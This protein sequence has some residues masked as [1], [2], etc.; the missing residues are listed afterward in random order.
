[1]V[2]VIHVARTVPYPVGAFMQSPRIE[3]HHIERSVAGNGIAI[4]VYGEM[5]IAAGEFVFAR[6]L[7]GNTL[8]VLL[9]TP[10]TPRRGRGAHGY[11]ANKHIF[12]KGQ[13]DNYA[14]IDIYD[15]AGAWQ[16]PGTPPEDGSIWLDFEAL[17]E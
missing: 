16:S 14:S 8:K 7:M 10:E 9:L 11:I 15:D 13:L 4:H 2:D 17:M 3:I 5:L 6:E 1:M 12:N